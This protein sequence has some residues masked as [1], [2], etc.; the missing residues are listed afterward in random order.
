MGG[1][2]NRWLFFALFLL[3]SPAQAQ[4]TQ[5]R[6]GRVWVKVAGFRQK[7]DKRFGVV[8]ERE[9]YL[10]N[11]TSDARAVVTDVIVGVQPNL[12]VWLQ[13]PYFDLRF[14]DAAQDLRTTGFG[15][16]RAWVRWQPITLFKGST[17]LALRAGVKTPIGDSPRDGQIIPV[18]EGQWDAEVFGEIG[19]SFWP[20]PAYGELW[21]GYRKRYPNG[22]L[23]KDP[24]NEFVF[25][26]EVGWNPREWSL[27]KVTVDGLRGKRFRSDRILTA[28]KRRLTTLQLAG[29]VRAGPTWPEFAVRIP[30]DGRGFIPAGPQYSLA[31]SAR[32]H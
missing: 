8:G 2:R 28:T 6:A 27:L 32:L 24:G 18:G 29:A 15:D 20:F 26:S 17:P 11:G 10:T 13:V 22:R 23:L 12:D 30:L 4:W 9:R 5:G 21:L 7:T 14:S 1:I 3:A 16:I 31:V 25:L 19:H